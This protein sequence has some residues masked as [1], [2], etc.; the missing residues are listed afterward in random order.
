LYRGISSTTFGG[1]RGLR[2]LALIAVVLTSAG[3]GVG[4]A[5][6][7]DVSRILPSPLDGPGHPR[8][9][10]STRKRFDKA[11]QLWEK[12]KTDKALKN[13]DR[14]GGGPAQDLFKLQMRYTPGTA[15]QIQ[16]LQRLTSGH[17]TY[18]AAWTT[19]FVTAKGADDEATAFHA[20]GRVSELWPN[21]KWAVQADD[22]RRTWV[23]GR[24]QRAERNLTDGN[25]EEALELVERALYLDPGNR[26]GL[27]VQA[28]IFIKMRRFGEAETVL[29]K[30]G[31]DPDA[32]MLAGHAAEL[33][34][35]LVTAMDRYGAAPPDTPGRDAALRRVQMTW[36]LSVLPPYVQESL[37]SEE[38]SRADVAVIVVNLVPQVEALGGGT[39]PLLSDIL[40]LP[41][42]REI[43]TAARLELLTVDRLEH[44]FSP[45]RLA[46]VTEIRTAVDRLNALLDLPAP[47]WCD[48]STMVSSC[49]ELAPPVSGG[50]MAELVISLVHGDSL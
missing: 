48:S 31:G 32:L 50:E 43:V 18:A 40:D 21:S 16:E 17:P 35:D 41:S 6:R 26:D 4:A 5:T 29:A 15:D 14:T 47:K 13:L 12:G 46:T 27:F 37:G 42:H 44:R 3:P 34:G 23:D 49:L 25:A 30:L 45:N 20:A 1:V 36:R 38:V 9:D 33:S 28:Q 2:T 10:Q 24:V 8:L 11:L 7:A 39:V 19:L 22:V